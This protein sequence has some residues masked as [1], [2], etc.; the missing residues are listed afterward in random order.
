MRL[1]MG[2]YWCEVFIFGSLAKPLLGKLAPLGVGIAITG[3]MSAILF[4]S[5]PADAAKNANKAASTF[6]PEVSE[7]ATDSA[8]TPKKLAGE[9]GAPR[10]G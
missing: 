5:P 1:K 8:R 4:P 9:Q 7:K 6:L 10:A 2:L 3:S